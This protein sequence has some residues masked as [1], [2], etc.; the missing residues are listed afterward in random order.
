ME[1]HEVK[2]LCDQLHAKYLEAEKYML[3]KTK[4]ESLLVLLP[5]IKDIYA[6]LNKGIESFSPEEEILD[7][8]YKRENLEKSKQ[9]FDDRVEAWLELSRESSKTDFP[10]LEQVPQKTAGPGSHVSRSTTSSVR[11]ERRRSAVKLKVLA[12][13]TKQEAQRV[14]E[15]R[16][17]AKMRAEEAKQQAR[18]KLQQAEEAAKRELQQ[19]EEAAKRELQ[20]AEEEADKQLREAE[21]E[22]EKSPRENNAIWT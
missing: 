1:S 6:T 10:S 18:I 16:Y 22:A 3:D 19:A 17:R 5:E 13:Q 20:E 14:Y 9:E 12:E 7:T 8:G 15:T 11:S 4:A 21:E 2:Y